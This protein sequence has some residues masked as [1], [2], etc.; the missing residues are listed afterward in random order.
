MLMRRLAHLTS[1]ATKI[2]KY[3][4]PSFQAELSGSANGVAAHLSLIYQLSGI[5]HKIRG[6]TVINIL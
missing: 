4:Y 5:P 6:L 1:N 2:S 3:K